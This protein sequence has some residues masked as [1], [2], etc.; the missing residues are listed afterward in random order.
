MLVLH[1]KSAAMFAPAAALILTTTAWAGA[2]IDDGFDKPKLDEAWKV[3][4]KDVGPSGEA[5]FK[6]AD[7]QLVVEKLTHAG[8]DEATSAYPTITF[9]RALP[10]PI[11]GDLDA[12]LD[13]SWDMRGASDEMFPIQY[14]WLR[15]LD[16][17][18]NSIAHVGYTDGHTGGPGRREW[19]IGV[20][21]GKVDETT[22]QDLSGRGTVG[23]RRTGEKVALRW[24]N[25]ELASGPAGEQVAAV[26]IVVR[27]Y[28][29][30]NMARN[31]FH[32][33]A[34]DRI[35]VTAP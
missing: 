24:G 8:S 1:R 21:E 25:E 32:R 7:G 33:V 15:L 17:K 29:Q 5:L 3:E 27:G 34:A 26:Q 28:Y 23:I 12:A 6:L 35:L 11:A 14:I 10:K 2:L 18:G 9:T 30:K 4:K 22:T 16:A 20:G 19:C 13:L 31:F